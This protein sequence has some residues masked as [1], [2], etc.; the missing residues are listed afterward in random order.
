MVFVHDT[1]P[2]I[3]FLQTHGQSKFDRHPSAVLI[4]I[5]ALSDCCSECD[6]LTGGYLYV[7]KGK[8]DW[9]LRR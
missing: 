4:D 5:D 3:D 8:G 1:P 7:M 2:A 9:L 6:V